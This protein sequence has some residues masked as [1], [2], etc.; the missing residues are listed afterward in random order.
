[1]VMCYLEILSVIMYTTNAK[2][3]PQNVRT[4]FSPVISPIRLRQLR[5]SQYKPFVQIVPRET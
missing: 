1:M 5:K 2:S 4:L 3:F